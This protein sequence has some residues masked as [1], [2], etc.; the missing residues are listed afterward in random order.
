VICIGPVCV[1]IWHLWFLLVFLLKPIVKWLNE[2]WTGNAL[3]KESKADEDCGGGTTGGEQA[4]GDG[5]CDLGGGRS[6]GVVV[7]VTTSEAWEALCDESEEHSVPLVV[8]F[9]AKWCNPCHKIAP[10]FERAAT[11][12]AATFCKVDIDAVGCVSD[13]AGVRVLPTFQV[14]GGPKPIRCVEEL[15]GAD[16]DKLQ[17]LLSAHCRRS[18]LVLKGD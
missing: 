3:L 11:Q 12:Y 10:H 13:K 9:T 8:N 14:W 7:E 17:A 4:G 16:T 6:P 18:T 5:L 2:K 15:I 1:P